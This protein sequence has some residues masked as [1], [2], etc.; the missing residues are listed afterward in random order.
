MKKCI[1]FL[2]LLTYCFSSI[3]ATLHTHYCMGE[4]IGTSFKKAKNN[5]CTKCGMKDSNKKKG[6]C[7]DEEKEYKIK[8]EYQKSQLQECAKKNVFFTPI[9]TTYN[10]FLFSTNFEN[11]KTYTNYYPPPIVLTVKLH[12]LYSVYLI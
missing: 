5:K 4:N 2:L 10:E 6:C 8:S 3:G 7:N 12:V 9:L 1:V 11:K